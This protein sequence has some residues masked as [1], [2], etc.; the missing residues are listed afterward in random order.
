MSLTSKQKRYL[1]GLG[2]SL[3]AVIH[4]GKNGLTDSLNAAIDAA[5][6]T[7]ELVKIRVNVE[8]PEDKDEVA[9]AVAEA[10]KAEIAQTLGHTALLYRARKK[11]PTIKLPKAGA[12]KGASSA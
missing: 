11:D 5:L 6:E 1:R 2:H 7:H 4:V 12:E 9:T 3:D 10:L 8:A